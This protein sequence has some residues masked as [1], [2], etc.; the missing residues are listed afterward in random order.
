MSILKHSGFCE[1]QQSSS[2]RII[3]S[4]WK[5]LKSPVCAVM[6]NECATNWPNCMTFEKC[7]NPFQLKIFL[8]ICVARAPFSPSLAAVVVSFG[9]A[10]LNSQVLGSPRRRHSGSWQ[11]SQPPYLFSSAQVGSLLNVS[12]RGFPFGKRPSWWRCQLTFLALGREE[13]LVSLLPLGK[14][15]P[16]ECKSEYFLSARLL[17]PMTMQRKWDSKTLRSSPSS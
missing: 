17:S 8:T 10:W 14:L 7:S 11:D 5:V 15:F 3:W 4:Y 13:D 2:K 6:E 12:E 1:E 9:H 16:E